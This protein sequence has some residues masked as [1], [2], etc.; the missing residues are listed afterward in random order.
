MKFINSDVKGLE[1]DIA[2]RK[3][4]SYIENIFRQN[5]DCVCYYKY[6]LYYSSNGFIPTFVLVDRELG[7]TVFKAYDYNGDQI[8]KI[9]ED[10]WIVGNKETRNEILD[11]EDYCYS[12]QSDINRPKNKLQNKV[13][14]TFYI[15]FPF[16]DAASNIKDSDYAL[17]HILYDDFHKQNIFGK[18]TKRRLSDRQWLTL[19]NIIQKLEPLTKDKGIQTEEP[20][21]NVAEAI[22]KNEKQICVFDDE[23]EM[24]AV[25]IPYGGVSIRGLAG[26]GKTIILTWKAAFIHYSYP[27]KKILYTFYTKSLYNQIKYLILSF[28]QK[29]A[30]EVPNW[31]NLNVLHAWGGR[32]KEGVYYNTCK[33]NKVQ[34][35]TMYGVRF[36]K[37]PFGLVC[38]DLLSKKLMKEYDYVLIDEAQDMPLE[39]FKL[40]EKI[41]LPPKA[42][43]IAYDELQNTEDITLPAFENLFK[44]EKNG[45]PKVPLKTEDDYILQRSYRNHRKILNLAVAVGFGLYSKQG[46]VQMIDR[47][48]NWN[49]AGYEVKK[50]K[51]KPGEYV[52][53]E[54]P[55]E[56]SPND[57]EKMFDKLETVN[58]V[59]ANSKKEELD[60]VSTS[61]IELIK[62]DKVKP[63]DI[64]VI[65]LDS[66]RV[67]NDYAY[68]QRRLA[69]LEIN[70]KIPGLIDDADDFFISGNVTLSSMRRAKGNEAPI[71]FV[72]SMNKVIA[73]DDKVSSRIIRSFAFVSITRAKGWCFISGY[74]PDMRLFRKEYE[75]IME[76][77]PRFKFNFPSLK[78]LEEIRQINYITKDEK[79]KKEYFDAIYNIKKLVNAKNIYLP[80][81]IKKQLQ[82]YLKKLK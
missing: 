17:S 55:A 61:I 27:N 76:D 51:L 65:N 82:Q 37:N 53:I 77:Y 46:V 69:Q 59:I 21:K 30:S 50:G 78:E 43:V 3:I 15:C 31:K 23:Q 20:P 66:H 32:T 24:A 19:R 11:L 62:K 74:G 22:I 39:F 81:E 41:T 68:I 60:Y 57:I 67:K 5:D 47:E 45:R 80:D 10:Y 16:L 13:P 52:E 26:T 34:P 71:V 14:L 70:T 7:I 75:S 6:P 40:I 38:K 44:Y 42:I 18:N 58:I 64:M 36:S 73:P 28:Y 12:L 8:T 49:A 33:N 4:F 56:N 72:M 48:E 35:Q 1:T 9:C 54:R 63:E 79:A 2:A 25:K 29:Y